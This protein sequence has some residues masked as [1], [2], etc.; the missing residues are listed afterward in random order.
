[1][2]NKYTIT[3]IFA[4]VLCLASFYVGMKY[5][6]SNASSSGQGNFSQNRSGQFGSGMMGGNRAGGM[7]AGG[8]FTGGQIISKDANSITVQLRTGGSTIVLYSGS[9]QIQKSVL[10]SV[11]DLNIGQQVTVTGS[12]NA[13]GSISAQSIQLRS[14][15]SSTT[16]VQG[17]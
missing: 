14:E 11:S 7:R 12:S 13:D 1:M 10:G 9:T 3:I 8:G 16:P 2:K 15:M 4:V 5:G 6:Q 17:K